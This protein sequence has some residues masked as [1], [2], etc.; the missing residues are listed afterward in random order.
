MFIIPSSGS[1]AKMVLGIF[2][3]PAETLLNDYNCAKNPAFPCIALH[4]ADITL[5]IA[6]P[7]VYDKIMGSPICPILITSSP[8]SRSQE[9]V[10]T[11]EILHKQAAVLRAVYCP[12]V[13]KSAAALLE[14]WSSIAT[15]GENNLKIS[16][17]EVIWPEGPRDRVT[18]GKFFIYIIFLGLLVSF[19]LPISIS[20][21]KL[22]RFSLNNRP[23]IG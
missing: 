14:R 19:P 3:L 20:L 13:K 23:L 6:T 10:S 2:P 18:Q 22:S 17:P 1:H 9:V 4:R 16:A 12:E 5:G 7:L 15:N 11:D 8:L 21:K